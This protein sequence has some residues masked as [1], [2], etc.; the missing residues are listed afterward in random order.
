[1][2]QKCEKNLSTRVQ[3]EILNHHDKSMPQ[4][5]LHILVHERPPRLTQQIESPITPLSHV[6]S[7]CMNVPLAYVFTNPLGLIWILVVF[8]LMK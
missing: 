7:S 5:T 6:T 4:E 1:M 8:G 3:A 2:G